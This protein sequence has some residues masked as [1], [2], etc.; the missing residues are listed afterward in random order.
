MNDPLDFKKEN[1]IGQTFRAEGDFLH[2]VSWMLPYQMKKNS[3]SDLLVD[4]RRGGPGGEVLASAVIPHD[5]LYSLYPCVAKF[6]APVQR[7][8]TLYVEMRP[9]DPIR[10][11]ELR[12]WAYPTDVFAGG[13]AFLDRKPV[14]SSDLALNFIYRKP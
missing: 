1:T 2:A 3:S 14:D 6:D 4:L 9:K 5:H 12:L 8:E 10:P 7:G 13:R 11:R